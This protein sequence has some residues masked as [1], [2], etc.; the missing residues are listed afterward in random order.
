MFGCNSVTKWL[1]I[2][3]VIPIIPFILTTATTTSSIHHHYGIRMISA[4][5][6]SSSSF[7]NHHQHHYKRS[8][9]QMLAALSS[10]SSSSSSSNDEKKNIDQVQVFSSNSTISSSRSS[11]SSSDEFLVVEEDY[12]ATK[13]N[14]ETKT[15]SSNFNYAGL[16]NNAKKTVESTVRKL[17]GNSEY[18]FGD[19]TMNVTKVAVNV[20]EQQIRTLTGNEEYKFGDLTRKALFDSDASLTKFVDDYYQRIP[21]NLFPTLYKDFS[22]DNK[23]AMTMSLQ[24]IAFVGLTLHFILNLTLSFNVMASWGYTNWKMKTLSL[25]SPTERWDL[26][27]RSKTTIELILGPIIL[28]VQVAFTFFLCPAY[29]DIVIWIEKRLPLRKKLTVLNRFMALVL[30]WFLLNYLS[31]VIMTYLGCSGLQYI[32]TLR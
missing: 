20:T 18:K 16:L 29:R 23:S 30:S 2:I 7:T 8:S 3:S 4:F 13:Q 32:F 9:Y 14:D 11:S 25:I 22:S 27:L 31:L 26:F 21:S 19:I 12:D 15:K 28:P 5:T 24:L 1:V 10:S 6:I 17:S